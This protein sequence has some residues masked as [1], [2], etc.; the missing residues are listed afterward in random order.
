LRKR[1]T[2]SAK[3]IEGQSAADFLSRRRRDGSETDTTEST[4]EE[5]SE[6]EN[7]DDESPEAV[8]KKRTIAFE[9]H[10]EEQPHD[11][12]AWI[13]Y[14]RL[15]DDIFAGDSEEAAKVAQMTAE[16]KASSKRGR[17]EVSLS[18]LDKALQV[19][20]QNRF[21]SR[22]QLEY[23]RIVEDVWPPGKITARWKWLLEVMGN[24]R[25]GRDE[26]EY[27]DI[28]L[29]YIGWRESRGLG[30]HSNG[31]RTESGGVDDVI[32]IYTECISIM[33]ES[34][35]AAFPG[36]THK[37]SSKCTVTLTPPYLSS[38]EPQQENLVYLLL[39]SCLFMRQ[40]GFAER[41]FAVMQAMLEL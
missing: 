39:R 37:P 5:A 27:M 24:A 38:G 25:S 14:A 26:R 23:M 16:M 41:A 17:A 32:A 33:R 34:M 11:I 10:L 31:D 20:E 35:L 30:T 29:A 40:A 7:F 19:L 36:G 22:L 18:I 21:S 4:F 3:R 28:W 15:H 12:S 13:D 2:R 9:R 6:E 8:L 1:R